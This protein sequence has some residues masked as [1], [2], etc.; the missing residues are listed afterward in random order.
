MPPIFKKANTMLETSLKI[1]FLFGQSEVRQLKGEK[2]KL[3][4]FYFENVENAN[5]F[6]LEKAWNA[7]RTKN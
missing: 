2:L 1:K 6:N 7:Y 3:F 5:L 4:R